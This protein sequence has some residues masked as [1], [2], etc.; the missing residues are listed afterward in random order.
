MRRLEI[1]LRPLPW[2]ACLLAVVAPA[3]AAQTP[4]ANAPRLDGRN[5]MVGRHT[6]TLAETG[7]PDQVVI[8]PARHELPL[9]LRIDGGEPT[10]DQLRFIGRGPR[11]RSPMAI[12]AVTGEQAIAAAVIEKANPALKGGAV[13]ARSKLKAGPYGIELTC[14]YRPRGV[15]DVHV[16]ASGGG[17]R[18]R[19][20]LLIQPAEP[21]DL[22]FA[23][24][25]ADFKPAAADPNRLAA[26]LGRAEGVVWDSAEQTADGKVNQL[27][28][29]SASAGFSWLCPKP[30]APPADASAV[31]ISRNPVGE[32][33]WATALVTGEKGELHFQLL[34]QPARA[35]PADARRKAWL[36]WPA[37]LKPLADTGAE[38]DVLAG[39]AE[40]SAAAEVV[41]LTPTPYLAAAPFGHFARM[42]GPAA[43]EMLSAEKD[44]V[45][46]YPIS[47]FRALTAGPTGLVARVEPNVRQVRPGDLPGYDRQIIGRA[48]LHDVGVDIRGLAQPGELLRVLA[49]L[50]AFGYFADDG[51]TEYVPYWNHTGLM[52]YGEA[53][54]PSS[55]FNLE[56]GD[57]AADTYVSAYRRPYERDGQKGTQTL[58][59]I[60]NEQSEGTR[61][62]LYVQA[63]KRIFGAGPRRPRG[64]EVIQEKDYGQVPD[65]SDWRKD[66]GW[67]PYRNRGLKDLEDG[68]FVRASENKGQTA[69]IYGPIHIPPKDFRLVWGYSLPNKE[70]GK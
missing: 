1:L 63:H 22:A 30:P 26:R 36:R 18:D 31:Q 52:R 15:V 6:V 29:G 64:L 7:L 65:D 23:G 2:A 41:K 60:V 62:R 67:V 5:V 16:A 21:T 4:D 27:Y 24:L 47:L 68:G 17:P 40:A 32:V 48:L 25:V 44:H 19:L 14:T 34:V 53:F 51:M 46:L 20:Q 57:P 39:G 38:T 11:L 61:L 54:D 8:A 42:A 70:K 43:A 3:L 10:R 59:V 13:V 28:V 35:K 58:F 55:A 50:E 69:E 56:T 9:E 33:T 37:G 49:A 45:A 66:R 12:Q